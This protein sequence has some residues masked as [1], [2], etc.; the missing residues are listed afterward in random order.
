MTVYS[1]ALRLRTAGEGEI[2]EITDDR[3]RDRTVLVDLLC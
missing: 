2:V 1:G 3:P